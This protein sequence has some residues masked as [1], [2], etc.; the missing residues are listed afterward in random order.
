MHRPNLSSKVL[1]SC[2]PYT[3]QGRHRS[4]T[5]VLLLLCL[6]GCPGAALIFLDDVNRVTGTS[7]TANSRR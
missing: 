6:K 7:V 1:S 3:F 5:I 2:P 4:Q